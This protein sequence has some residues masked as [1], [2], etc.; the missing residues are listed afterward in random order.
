MQISLEKL[1]LI[2][3]AMWS[4]QGRNEGVD[5]EGAQRWR[6]KREKGKMEWGVFDTRQNK[7]D[8]HKQRSNERWGSLGKMKETQGESA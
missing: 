5:E 6:K 3:F 1:N 4:L 8:G 2:R 7:K